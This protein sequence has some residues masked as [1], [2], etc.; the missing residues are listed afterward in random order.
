M[1]TEALDVFSGEQVERARR[2]HRP[3]YPALA[4]D[5]VVGI[6]GLA[7]LAFTRVGDAA[8]RQVDGRPWWADTLAFVTVVLVLTTL[9]RLPVSFWR[10]YLHEKEWDLSTQTIFGWLADTGKG[11]VVTLVFSWIWIGGLI[12]VAR[13]FPA[14]WP[15]VAAV[16]SAV[17]VLVVGFVAPVV[18]EPLFN[19][20]EPLADTEFAAEL[21]SL[22]RS[23]GT[24][25]RDVLVADASRRTKKSNAYVSG[26]GAT[27]RVVLYDTLLERSDPR[28]VKLVI[29]HELGHRQDRHVAKGTAL[30]MLGAVGAVLAI[31]AL[32]LSAD[33]RAAVGV[34]GAGDPRVVPFLML[35]GVVLELLA[36]PFGTAL[37]RRW[38]RAA[39]RFSLEVTRDPEAFETA[40]RELATSNLSDL[41]PPRPLY[42]LT[43]SHPTPV[44]R[45]AAARRWGTSAPA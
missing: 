39:D 27:R 24:P 19:R 9:V 20:F 10:S 7:I 4:V 12:V 5:L 22:A 16:G 40:H 33:V 17:F 6:G 45:I 13:A 2:Y 18:L 37:S 21:R 28:A 31:W 35:V 34:G 41:Q 25:V 38:E 32:L 23:A 26:F 8:F 30:G 29:A 1:S 42:V 14:W 43:F 36:L 3:L 11:F 44:E 15:L